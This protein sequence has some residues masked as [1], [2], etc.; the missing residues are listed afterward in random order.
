MLTP[1]STGPLLIYVNR[2]KWGEHPKHTNNNNKKNS[3]EKEKK[4]EVKT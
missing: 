1:T 2:M 4:K 3:E